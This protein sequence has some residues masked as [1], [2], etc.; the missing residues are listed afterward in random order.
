MTNGT[1]TTD[2]DATLEQYR[3]E[4]TGY[5]Y[6]MLGSSFEAEDAVQ[7][8][9]IRAWRSL[10]KFEGR[11][12]LR[13]W[14]YRIAT[15]VCL[16]MLSA[17]NKRA[18]P[19]DLTESTPLAQAALSPRPDH[20]WLEPMPDDRVL[21]TPADPAE[22]AVAKESVRLAFMAALQKLPAKQRAV[23]ILR[24]VLA[25]KASEVAELL[26]TSVASVNSAL[27][28]ARATL[29]ER[30]EP[31]ADAAVSD[32]LD[33]DQKKLLDRYVAAFEGYDMSALTALLHEDAVMTMPPFDLWL[34]G[35]GDITGF[36]TTLGAAC[37][38]SRLV[39]VEVNGLPGFAQYKPDPENGG[40]T[41][42][43][44]QALEISDGR[45]T[46]FHCFLDT[47][48]WFP[49]FGLPLRLEAETDEVEQGAQRG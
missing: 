4:L 42:W 8:T 26:G 37:A 9:M 32:P 14:L 38:H 27:Q 29:A 43:A 15:N 17:G 41:P 28:R 46:G 5:C 23:L 31:G 40:Y 2:P 10:D 16:D 1:A 35:A 11:S 33:E 12:S 13:S 6:R 36:M 19:M 3:V 21:P 48:R 30:R 49:L 39:P 34:T 22:A 47:Q 24:E 18:R 20:T 7:D 25:W 45:I 44:V